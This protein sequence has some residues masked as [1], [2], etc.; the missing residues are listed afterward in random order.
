MKLR[1]SVLLLG[2][3]ESTANL[4]QQAAAVETR[5]LGVEFPETIVSGSLKLTCN[6]LTVY[7]WLLE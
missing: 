5:R 4:L 1:Q 6:L 2:N 3:S 7:K